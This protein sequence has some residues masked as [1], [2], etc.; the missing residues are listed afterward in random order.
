MSLAKLIRQSAQV[1]AECVVTCEA[2]HKPM[3]GRSEDDERGM[4]EGEER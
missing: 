1:S 4:R 3:D 2:S